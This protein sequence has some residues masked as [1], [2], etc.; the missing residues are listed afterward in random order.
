MKEFRH[1]LESSA[2]YGF[3]FYREEAQRSFSKMVFVLWAVSCS[4]VHAQKLSLDQA[5]QTALKNNLGIKSAEY[6]IEYFKQL[7]KTGSDIGKL[8]AVWT[9][10]QYNSIYQDNNFTLSQTIPFP[11]TISNQILL[12]KEQVKTTFSKVI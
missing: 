2:L 6:Q 12:G 8:S 11:T 7:K 1:F 5:V 10:G 9:H 4:D 3:N